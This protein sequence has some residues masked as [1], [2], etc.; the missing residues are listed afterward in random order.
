[1]AFA[2]SLSQVRAALAEERARLCKVFGQIDE[3]LERL[4]PGTYEQVGAQPID[5]YAPG[6]IAPAPSVRPSSAAPDGRQAANNGLYFYKQGGHAAPLAL[7]AVMVAAPR[8]PRPLTPTLPPGAAWEPSWDKGG[9]D[10]ETVAAPAASR[11]PAPPRTDSGGVAMRRGE[12]V[13]SKPAGLTRA[14]RSAAKRLSLAVNDVSDRAHK[15]SSRQIFANA[16]QM[17]EQV[18]QAIL[19]PD[20]DVRDMYRTD[21]HFQAIAR[22]PIFDITGL[23]LILLNTLWLGLETDHNDAALLVDAE[24]QFI[25]V[26]NFFCT[27]FC[28]ELFIRFMA[29]RSKADIKKD[30]WFMFD[31]VL[32]L[33]MALET[34]VV[35][36]LVLATNGGLSASSGS[37]SVLKVV[38][39]F[40]MTRAARV[41][42]LLKAVPELM[43]IGRG[44]V[45]VARTVIVIMCLLFMI[46]YTFAIIFTQ[47]AKGTDLEKNVHPNAKC[48]DMV[49]TMSTLLLGGILPDFAPT[50]EDF[51][52]EDFFFAAF[53]FMFILLA[54]VTI[55]NMLIG[56]LV[57]VVAVVASVEKETNQVAAVK[58]VLLKWTPDTDLDGDCRIGVDEFKN[59]LNNDGCAKDLNDVGVD[60]V[61]LIDH[62]DF[63]YRNKTELTFAELLAVV[64]GLRGRNDPK[65][66]DLVQLRKFL[67]VEMLRIEMSLESLHTSLGLAQPPPSGLGGG[68]AFGE[69]SGFGERNGFGWGKGCGG[70]GF[71]GG[72]NC[73][74]SA[75]EPPV[76]N[77]A[78]VW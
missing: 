74:T 65:V 38:R 13:K 7:D 54:Y 52:A 73:D 62:A 8:V 16:D 60:A 70:N 47:L 53:F 49:T 23:S 25:I 24:P 51:A 50:T 14:R 37:A 10:D 36:I 29:F 44:I 2:G 45:I 56:V 21:G 76:H 12:T 75:P 11:S 58:R 5:V 43:V 32:V 4:E 78:S 19:Q 34:W 40:R 66:Q 41:A 64:L 71:G 39:L 30:S 22:S 3:A 69:G 61:A 27:V 48:S 15:T 72:G 59:M 55:M 46:I 28:L 18:Q 26:E 35:S 77:A 20:Y 6:A 42:R 67:H 63:V 9:V 68:S 17:K 33:F 1:M 31:S 57:E